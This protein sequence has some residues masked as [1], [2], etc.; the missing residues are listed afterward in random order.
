MASEQSH[1]IIAAGD[2]EG[3]MEYAMEQAR[4]SPP[5]PTKFCVGAV[6]VDAFKN[7]FLSTRYSKEKEN[8][9]KKAMIQ[10]I[11]PVEGYPS[12]KQLNTAAGLATVAVAAQEAQ[13]HTCSDR[14]LSRP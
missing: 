12:S 3:Y 9:R 2:P 5:A 8:P 4:L 7:E 14:A 13:N 1:P 6:L 11:G 10:A